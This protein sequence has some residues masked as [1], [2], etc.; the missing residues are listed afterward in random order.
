MALVAQALSA[1]GLG[2]LG[3]RAGHRLPALLGQ[4]SLAAGALLVLLP[5]PRG[6][7]SFWPR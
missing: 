7:S 3:D 2:A 5:P 6:A 1:A 4:A